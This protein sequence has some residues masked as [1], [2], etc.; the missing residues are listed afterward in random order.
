MTNWNDI[1][2][3]PKAELGGAVNVLVRV[4]SRN[5]KLLT[6]DAW[7]VNHPMP[8]LD[9]G[10]EYPDWAALCDGEPT[11]FVG[12]ATLIIRHDYDGHS[13]FEPLKGVEL[14]AE[15]EYPGVLEVD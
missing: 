10:D 5:E 1:S 7:Y 3:A 13:Y 2:V 12:F 9:D 11:D 8:S 4:R 14:W 6:L 15:I